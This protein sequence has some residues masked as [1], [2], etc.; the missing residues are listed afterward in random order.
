ML[1]LLLFSSFMAT[2]SGTYETR[3][4]VICQ[5]LGSEVVCASGSQDDPEDIEPPPNVS[6]W[7]LKQRK[8]TNPRFILSRIAKQWNLL[9]KKMQAGSRNRGMDEMELKWEKRGMRFKDG[10][11]RLLRLC[12]Q[13]GAN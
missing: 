6:E 7:N 3:Q 4:T 9:R 11:I 2:M 12:E 8:Q 13:S 5:R 10:R 1:K